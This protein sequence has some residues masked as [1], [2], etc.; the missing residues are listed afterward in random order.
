MPLCE[1][2]LCHVQK[3]SEDR[4]TVIQLL[5]GV[6]RKYTLPSLVCER[7]EVYIALKRGEEKLR[8]ASSQD[9]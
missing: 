7:A 4:M 2:Y 6:E 8:T 1:T 3:R 5:V 9:A